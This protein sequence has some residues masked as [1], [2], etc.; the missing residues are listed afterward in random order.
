[1]KP[2]KSSEPDFNTQQTAASSRRRLWLLLKWTLFA[3]VIVFVGIQGYELWNKDELQQI[4]INFSWLVP[5]GVV[6]LLGGLP[7]VWFWQRLMQSF[8]G[9]VAYRDSLR[10]YYCGQLGKYIPGKATV[11]VIRSGMLKGRGLGAA[12]AA[13][14]ATGETLIMM[15]T[16]LAVAAALSPMI[17][18]PKWIHSIPFASWLAPILVVAACLAALK[19]I[20]FALTHLAVRMTPAEM[21]SSGEQVHIPA[22]VIGYGLLAFVVTWALFG[23]SLGLTVRSISDQAIDFAN[24]PVWTGA[25][26]AATAIGFLAIFAPGGLAVREGLLFM[27]LSLHIDGKQAMAAAVLLRLVWLVAEITAAGVL[28][29]MGGTNSVPLIPDKKAE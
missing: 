5:A 13:I 16:G 23:L 15:G 11:L 25:V 7:A 8:G 29:Y 1:V 20:S 14:T 21:I 12:A 19:V 3:L 2:V 27:V 18:W 24:W 9:D 22:R 4:E 28:Y 17:G 10:A 6:Y 26:S